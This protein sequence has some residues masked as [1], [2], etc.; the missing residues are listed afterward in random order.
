MQRIVR[1][2][3]LEDQRVLDGGCKVR[4]VEE[5]LEVVHAYP[6]ALGDSGCRIEAAERD[7]YTVHRNV[8]ED[9]GQDHTRNTEKPKRDVSLEGSDGPAFLLC[10]CWF[11]FHFSLFLLFKGFVSSLIAAFPVVNILNILLSHHP[12]MLLLFCATATIKSVIQDLS[13]TVLLNL[14]YL[15]LPYLSTIN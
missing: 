15:L 14:F 7:L 8:A 11:L 6:R 3:F 5:S 10:F 13:N 4:R 9:E 12:L 2:Q 1:D